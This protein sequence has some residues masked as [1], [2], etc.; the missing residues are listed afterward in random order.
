MRQNAKY[1]DNW[2]RYFADAQLFD[3]VVTYPATKANVAKVYRRRALKMH[4][5]RHK[6]VT[7]IATAAFQQLGRYHDDATEYFDSGAVTALAFGQ[8]QR[9]AQPRPAS[10]PAQP[11]PASPPPPRRTAEKATKHPFT[12]MALEGFIHFYTSRPVPSKG[13]SY[14]PEAVDA[15]FRLFDRQLFQPL[16]LAHRRNPQEFLDAFLA[17]YPAL[18]AR[19]RQPGEL[20]L[21]TPSLWLTKTL[22][23]RPWFPAAEWLMRLALAELVER[24]GGMHFK[25]YKYN[26]D[27]ALRIAEPG[28]VWH[29]LKHNVYA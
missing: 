8:P 6:N 19:I 26:V 22:P 20:R 14:E 17:G 18:L 21:M 1:A 16:A 2:R 28:T 12:A 7:A 5:D 25:V 23:K 24:S 9:P 29:L 15:L 10:P 4:P 27:A 13:P 11:R 3:N